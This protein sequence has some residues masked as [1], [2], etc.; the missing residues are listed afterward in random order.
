MKAGWQEKKLGEIC[1]L[2]NGRAYKK[3]ELLDQGKYP[4]LR[5]GNFFTNR[6]WYYSDLELEDK[7][8]C[9]NG[10]LLY[11]WSASFGPKIWDG[12]KVIYHYHIWKV[13]PEASLVTKKFLYWLFDWD[14]EEIKR[15]QGTGTTMIHVSKGSM[16]NRQIPLP[17][18][19]EQQR[20]VE[21]LDQAFAAIATA[22]A[23][24]QQNLAN[25]RELFES[26]LDAVFSQS[27]DGWVEN[28]LIEICESTRPITYGVIKLGQAMSD[29]IPCLRT[30]NV[31]WLH[32]DT[33]GI[34]KI[35]PS[36]SND[37]SR[38]ILRGGEVLVNV[39]GT[40][41][42]VAVVPLEMAGWNVS[43]EV[44]MVPID[45]TKA[46]PVFVSYQIGSNKSQK[47]FGGVKK[48]AAYVGIN[49]GDLRELPVHLPTI[50]DQKVIVK[51]LDLLSTETKKLEAIY[52]QKIAVL[53][54]LKQSL[55]QQA[56]EGEL[57]KEFT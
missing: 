30:S 21:I 12:E 29:G 5:V 13:I 41:G 28:Q 3:P 52:T 42:G 54:E 44:A 8:Y 22:R 43:R 6:S 2:V 39:R 33:K 47:W 48:G 7:K 35:D 50:A 26:V 36:L 24:A 23:N 32:I 4:V 46:D 51:K 17:P 40:L 20:I 18:L 15:T 37:Y 57:T 27:N 19:A 45:S 34:K 55:L 11:A 56:F 31:R 38:T 16:E 25:A 1:T 14:K 9:D 49:L 53:D 10:D